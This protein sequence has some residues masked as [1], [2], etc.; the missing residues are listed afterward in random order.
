MKTFFTIVFIV[1]MVSVQAQN[2]KKSASTIL[3]ITGAS[4]K[5][6]PSNILQSFSSGLTKLG[7]NRYWIKENAE[8]VIRFKNSDKSY[9]F[10][11]TKYNIFNQDLEV[12]LGGL[13]RYIKN[14]DVKS[15]SLTYKGR[16]KFFINST[17][18]PLQEK[19]KKGGYFEILENGEV[20][21]L[22]KIVFEIKESNYN[23]ALSVGEKNA[24]IIQ[25]SVYYLA[26]GSA[27][28]RVKGRK[29]VTKLFTTFGFDAKSAIKK[30]RFKVKKE[31]DLK[32]L[33]QL[34]NK[35]TG[36]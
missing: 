18:Y 17:F 33:V 20:Q 10:C 25:K 11:N 36:K 5:V 12:M 19:K 29:Q 1:L 24:S 16:Q 27:I 28:E 6:L 14:K 8:G 7:G 22:K 4:S 23:V 3:G 13:I 2:E 26:K 31:A 21:L 35:N 9:L 34:C 32:S 15:F 30:Y